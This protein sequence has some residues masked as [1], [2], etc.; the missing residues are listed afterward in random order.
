MRSGEIQPGMMPITLGIMAIFYLPYTI[1]VVFF[2]RHFVILVDKRP[3]ETF[4][5]A[6]GG[7]WAAELWLGLALGFGLPALIFAVSY[8]AGWT[9]I[10]GSLFTQPPSRILVVLAQTL[11]A[12][13]GVAVTEEM[14]VR[15]YI[16]QTLKWGYGTATALIASSLLFGLVH[17]FN[18]GAAFL[19]FLGTAGAGLFLGYCYLVTKRLWLP[20]GWHFGWNF[21]LGPIFGFPVSGMDIPAWVVQKTSGPTLWTG[22]RFGPEASLMMVILLLLG[23]LAIKLII[24]PSDHSTI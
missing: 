21:A 11:V 20:I 1:A 15:G 16:L 8:L 4:G 7:G 23:T 9:K 6:R 5:L 14:I 19:A 13:V 22:G 24:R 10:T 17:L 2:T 18:P 3:F 12:L